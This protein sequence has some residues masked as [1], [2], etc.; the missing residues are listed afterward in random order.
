MKTSNW[1]VFLI[2]GLIAILFGVFVLMVSQD[3]MLKYVRYFG[4]FILVCG[5][6]LFY[7]SYRN[8]KAN[9]SY[10]LNMV[11][12]I[13]AF[14]IGLLIAINPGKSLDL[15]MTLIGIWAA[16]MGL[17][18]II[19]SVRMRKKVTNHYL[20]SI[21]GVITLVFGLLLFYSQMGTDGTLSKVIGVLA[22]VAGVFLIYL[23]TKVKAIK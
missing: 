5:L 17:L 22:V 11:M 1:F 19:L 9:K 20:F 14:L 7:F 16:L 18:Q 10:V 2:N 23:S 13:F 12:S 6:V 15:F 4:I 8:K 3:M 21:N